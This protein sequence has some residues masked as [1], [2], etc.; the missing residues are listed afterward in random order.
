M[1]LAGHVKGSVDIIK[2]VG[3]WVKLKRAGAGP[4]WVGLCPFHSEKTPSFGVHSVHQFYKCF[5]CGAAGDVFSFV[6]QM[7]GLSFFEA[8]KLIAERNGIALPQRSEATDDA[9]KRRAALYE[10]HEIAARLFQ[11]NLAGPGGAEAR[12]YLES[13]GVSADTAR[14]F[15]LGLSEPSGQQLV[16]AFQQR[17]FSAEQQEQS[18]LL[19]KRQDGSGSYDRFRGRLMFPIHNETGKTIAFGGRAMRPDDEPKYLNSSDTPIYHKR[20]VLYN[21]HR[22]K[23]AIRKS[24]RA[25]L[26]EGYMDVIGVAAAGVSEVVAS[27][28]T[29]LTS[30]Q[31][32]SIRRHAERIVVNFDPDA[33]GSNAAE[34]CLHLLLDEQMHVRILELDGGL[35][36]DDYIRHNGVA[37]YEARLKSAA[38]YFHWLADRARRSFDMRS[39]EGRIEAWKFLQPSVNRIQDKLERMTIVNDL[40]DYL[41]VDGAAILEQFRR[42]R[43]AN[44]PAQEPR[45]S[46][47]RVEVPKAERLLLSCLLSSADAR[48]QVLPRLSESAAVAT[49]HTRNILQALTAAADETGEFRFA[50][51]EGRLNEDDRGV[52]AALIFADEIGEPT[53]AVAQALECLRELE[54]TNPKGRVQ[55]LQEQIRVAER[56]GNTAE[57]RLLMNELQ[58]LKRGLRSMSR[59]VN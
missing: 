20:H 11:T 59:G 57:A 51:V 52:L 23:N 21:L 37:Q 22:A 40:A 19:L 45:G 10:M 5:G 39:A 34:K 26:V 31:V 47:P 3:E 41:G 36:P 35:D 30:E 8:L 44:G 54:N 49:L 4:R 50:D 18:G 29:A 46:T 24:E 25:I 42:Q 16:R 27:C 53:A 1:D 38:P 12:R 15:G 2:V 48:A 33:A 28:G 32:R 7:E 6:M 9:A 43:A 55:V 17:G 56:N 13:R 58:D 14:E